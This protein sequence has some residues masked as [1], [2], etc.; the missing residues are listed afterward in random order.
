MRIRLLSRHEQGVFILLAIVAIGAALCIG[1]CVVHSMLK[2]IKEIERKK[3]DQATN[4]PPELV[5]LSQISHEA[6][7]VVL[8]AWWQWVPD[9]EIAAAAPIQ[10]AW[11]TST[12]LINWEPVYG[13]YVDT[14]ERMRFFRPRHD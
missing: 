10:Q 9:D 11:E 14:T 1:G 2:H 13:P 4:A 7:E 12:N 6:N 5:A 8:D 3:N